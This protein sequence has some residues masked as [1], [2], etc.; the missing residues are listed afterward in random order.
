MGTSFPWGLAAI[1]FSFS[2]VALIFVVGIQ[3]VNPRSAAQWR[4]PSWK[5][6]PFRTKEPLQFFHLAGFLFVAAGLGAIGNAL[7]EGSRIYDG[8]LFVVLGLGTVAGVYICT[9]LYGRKMVHGA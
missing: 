8:A 7:V 6:N 4:Y 2:I 1:L 9:V 3:F 5:L